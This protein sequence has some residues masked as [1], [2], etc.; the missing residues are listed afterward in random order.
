[1]K[2]EL[3]KDTLVYDS[4]N[5]LEISKKFKEENY[6]ADEIEKHIEQ[7]ENFIISFEKHLNK[8][9]DDLKHYSKSVK[10]FKNKCDEG[11]RKSN[12]TKHKICPCDICRNYQIDHCINEKILNDNKSL[13]KIEE[14]QNDILLLQ[15]ANDKLAQKVI[16]FQNNDFLLSNSISD[17]KIKLEEANSHNI[18]LQKQ[19]EEYQN[20]VSGYNVKK[21]K[22][23]LSEKNKILQYV[24]QLM[25]KE[26]EI[27]EIKSRY[28]FELSEGEKMICVSFIS[29][30]EDIHYSIICNITWPFRECLDWKGFVK[31]LE[32]KYNS[33]FRC[34]GLW[35][36]YKTI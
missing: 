12:I 6:F 17:L 4:K 19:I 21:K 33:S 31:L 18:K 34:V 23:N 9:K 22:I 10:F 8:L 36:L 5:L 1:M 27:K 26:K 7:I 24:E 28:P 2:K 16:E 32:N 30:N 3:W 11:E 15:K 35:K 20:F 13:K 25:E 14:L 29:L